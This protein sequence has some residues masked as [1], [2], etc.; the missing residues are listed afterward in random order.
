ML[1]PSPNCWGMSPLAAFLKE[2]FLD[3]IWRASILI[4]LFRSWINSPLLM[5]M[6]QN[7][8]SKGQS[9]PSLI[10]WGDSAG[11][12]FHKPTTA[13]SFVSQGASYPWPHMGCV[14]EQWA[15]SQRYKEQTKHF[16]PIIQ[17][18]VM[19]TAP[20]NILLLLTVSYQTVLMV[21]EFSFVTV[22][23]LWMTWEPIPSSDSHTCWLQICI[24]FHAPHWPQIQR[25]ICYV[26]SNAS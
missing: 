14:C 9:Q 2:L 16:Q 22:L 18:I 21:A 15:M 6:T 10:C 8:V 3:D 12:Y 4:M 20:T 25:Y 7:R 1:R 5:G 19:Q 23:P 26:V 11:K 24:S 13:F 17:S